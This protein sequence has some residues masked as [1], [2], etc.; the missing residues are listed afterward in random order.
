MPKP[1]PDP[2]FVIITI[3]QE[4]VHGE[5]NIRDDDVLT[6]PAKISR[7]G[8]KVCLQYLAS[9]CKIWLSFTFARN[10]LINNLIS[11]VFI[12][13][14]NETNLNSSKSA[15]RYE[16]FF[17]GFHKCKGNQKYFIKQSRNGWIND[18]FNFFFV[19]WNRRFFLVDARWIINRTSCSSY[20]IYKAVLLF[21]E[22]Q[23]KCM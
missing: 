7:T 15:W 1:S 13:S 16:V 21:W 6:N 18:I 9:L 2:H 3:R 10:L 23:E 8:M 14:L 12:D 22:Q 17:I 11:S 4:L 20:L 19:A 5:R